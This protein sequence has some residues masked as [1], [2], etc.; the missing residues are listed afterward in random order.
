MMTLREMLERLRG[1]RRAPALDA[2]MAE[3]M[4]FHIDMHA[5]QLVEGGMSEAEARREAQLRFGSVDRFTEEGRSEQ[6]SRLLED[7][8]ADVR[9]ATRT[10]LR[11]PA[12]TIVALLSLGLGIG[13]NTAIF[14][15]V[16][17]VLLR[18]LPYAQPDR[19]V[20]VAIKV[21]GDER[22][23]TLSV[24]DFE[25]L[26]AA[27][28]LEAIGAYRQLPG[29]ISYVGP[30]GPAALPATLATSGVF[31]ALGVRPHLGRLPFAE[32]DAPGAA[33]VVVLSH[34]AWRTH[35][36][37]REDVIGTSIS[38][39]SEPTT[40]IAV[41][42]E[43][44]RIGRGTMN[45]VWPIAQLDPPQG[46]APFWL[47]SI[48]RVKDGV[49]LAT[50][51]AELKTVAKQ[52][53]ATWGSSSNV[54]TYEVQPLKELIV[55]DARNTT[56]VLFGAVA[57][58]LLIAAANVANLLVARATTRTR[59]MAVR[60]ALGAGR[61]RIVR[62]LLTESAVLSVFGAVLGIALAWI[63]LRVLPAIAPPNVARLDSVGLNATVLIFTLVVSLATGILVGLAPALRMP[64]AIA[65]Q[66]NEGGRGRISGGRSRMRTAAVV[67]EFALALTVLIGAGLVVTSLR[68]LQSVD[69]G[70]RTSD[71][72]TAQVVVPS[73]RY[74]DEASIL[75]V[76]DAFLERARAVPGVESVA[77]AMGLPPNQLV[78]RNP[79]VLDG[80]MPGAGE[81][82]EVAQEVLMTPEMFE[83][84]GMELRAGRA[85]TDAD[86]ATAPPVM[87]VNDAFVKKYLQGRD[88]LGH[89]V[90]TGNPNPENLRVTIVGVVSDVR[91]QGLD[92]APEPTMYVPFAQ[93]SWWN[94]MSVV[95]RTKGGD[96]MA[97]APGLRAALHA[98]DSELPL[99]DV[100]TLEML[101]SQSVAS[102]RFRSALLGSFALL[103]LVLSGAGIY[104]I[105]A[106]DV[107]QRKRE[108]AV[109]MALGATRGAVLR[110][111]VANGAR[112]AIG[113]IVIGLA[114][115]LAVTRLLRS[116]L[117]GVEPTDLATFAA[118]SLL[119]TAVALLGCA[120]PA[121]RAARIQ[122][123]IALNSE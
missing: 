53:S 111:V 81:N 99:R 30:D 116:L 38:L 112:I 74:T 56:L 78:M 12:F 17:A 121:W 76:Y 118:M 105:I 108:T 3:E 18:P 45:E 83:T 2:E 46:R 34:D 52:V 1:T 59:E 82:A 48:A 102:P 50:A 85:F 26:K 67:L 20:D 7:L 77:L 47:R 80:A 15:V 91:Y 8:F 24:A 103:A 37:G 33:P 71:V 64:R 57:M 41:M 44:F 19:V 32:E 87:I 92:L 79:M 42:P 89:T 21:Q 109:R 110:A 4:R 114:A 25:G 73:A 40:I 55:Q 100:K 36:G 22:G 90:Q 9:Y 88:P 60:T 117:Y 104:G 68:R 96:P 23:S 123:Q 106:Y 16:E 11:T 120:V 72:L 65:A 31:H 29:G 39:A 86:V 27:S 115:A 113:G 94:A 95:V 122:P 70:V 97:L 61:T 43:G 98:V 14:S 5:A 119:L 6:R 101:H 84:L 58:V 54:W 93:N 75:T 62:Q 107:S 10:L 35:F 13:A 66:M 63:V 49:T 69:S 28:S 51:D